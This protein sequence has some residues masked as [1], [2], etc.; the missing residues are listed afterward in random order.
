MTSRQPSLRSIRRQ[1]TDSI[2]GD[3]R[4]GRSRDKAQGE[5]E[6]SSEHG[7]KLIEV[8]LLYGT[9]P[10]MVGMMFLMFI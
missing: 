6:K 9:M 10:I 2:V 1:L 7:W 4:E 3:R 8:I 5:D